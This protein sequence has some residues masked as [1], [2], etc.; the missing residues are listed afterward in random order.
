MPKSKGFTLIE[1]LIVIAIIAVLSVI[2]VVVFKAV[3]TNARDTKRKADLES[4]TKAYEVKYTSTGSYPVLF[5]TDFAFGSVPKT[6]EGNNYPCLIGPDPSCVTQS[7]DKVAYCVSLG[8]NSSAPC[9]SNSST[10]Y[11]TASTQGS[12]FSGGGFSGGGGG[13]SCD[14]YGVLTSGL[15]GYWKLDEGTGPTTADSSGNSNI[16]TWAG[17][18]SHWLAGK[19]SNSGNFNGIDDYVNI[20]D[21]GTSSVFDLTYQ[22]TLSLWIKLNAYGALKGFVGKYSSTAWLNTKFGIVERGDWAGVDTIQ[23]VISDGVNYDTI[24]SSP[25]SLSQWHH[26]VYTFDGS[27]LKLYKNGTIDKQQVQYH[28]PSVD[29]DPIRIGTWG[30]SAGSMNGQIDDVRIYNRALSASEVSTLY[31]NGNGCLP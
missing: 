27:N 18:G 7:T 22:G 12:S 26:I 11:C 15:V 14:P 10:C 31:N 8:D 28:T 6:P 1:L 16:G 21:P 30:G 9:Y 29:D 19:F 13:S 17:T 20:P 25:L 24:I 2:G 3:S 23:G 5:G 4:I